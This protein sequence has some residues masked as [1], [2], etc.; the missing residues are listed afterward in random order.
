MS[1][2]Q[3]HIGCDQ[4]DTLPSPIRDSIDQDRAMA[5]L[6]PLQPEQL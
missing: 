6:P 4:H 5:Y 1:R 2:K 3:L